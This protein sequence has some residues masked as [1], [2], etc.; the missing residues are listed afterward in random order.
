MRAADRRRPAGHRRCRALPRARRAARR[1][2]PWTPGGRRHPAPRGLGPAR[3]RRSRVP[4]RPEVAIRRRPDRRRTGRPR[5]R[6]GGRAT[7]RQGPDA[8]ASPAAPRP[9]R[10]PAGGRRGRCGPDRDLCRFRASRRACRRS[11]GRSASVLTSASPSASSTRPAR[12]SRARNRPPSTSS[13]R[14]MRD[15]PTTPPRPFE[16]GIDGR[17]TLVQNVETLAQAAL[18][19]RR[20]DGWYRELGRATTPGTALVT[21]GG[22]ERNGVR[23]IEIGTTVGDLALEAGAAA[24]EDRQA[25]LLGGYFGGWLSTARSWTCPSTRHRC[26]TPGRRSAPASSAFLG[27]DRCA[28]CGRRPRSSTG[29]PARPPPSAGPASSASGRSPTR[30]RVCH[31]TAERDDLARIERWSRQLAGAAPAAIPTAPS[32]S[33]SARSGV[34]RRWEVHQTRGTC[35]RDGLRRA[36]PIGGSPRCR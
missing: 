12:T 6:R 22:A 18:I 26:A 4:G 11:S 27:N 34:R 21:V 17:P 31:G 23:E 24:T 15:R 16:R 13:T 35:S 3:S 5:Q 19:A 8:P 2:A 7:Q 10:R 36:R 20:G 33:S 9:R 30:R 1:A 25:V 29:W 32:A 14:P 28:A